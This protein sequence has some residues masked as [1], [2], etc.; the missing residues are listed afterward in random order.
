[1]AEACIKMEEGWPYQLRWLCLSI[2]SPV[3]PVL[4]YV[5]EPRRRRHVRLVIRRRR[6]L[7][8]LP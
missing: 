2:S 3:V 5:A 8:N 6:I 1:M 7:G 4:Q